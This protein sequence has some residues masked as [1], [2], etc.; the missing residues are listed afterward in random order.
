VTAAE[1]APLSLPTFRLEQRVKITGPDDTGC[2]E[3][4]GQEGVVAFATPGDDWVVD[5]G[6]MQWGWY[7]GKNL[8]GV[9]A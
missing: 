5:F 4:V 7:A 9:E 2:C 6:D 3:R 1:L 8:Q